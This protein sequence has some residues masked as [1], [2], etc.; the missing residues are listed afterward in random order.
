[1]PKVRAKSK[2]RWVDQGPHQNATTAGGRGISQRNATYQRARAKAKGRIGSLRPSGP[3]TTQVLSPSSG[4]TGG[5]V[6]RK[7]KER[8]KKQKGKEAWVW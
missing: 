1:M 4:V 8:A 7:E 2:A 5:Q 3:S 6:T